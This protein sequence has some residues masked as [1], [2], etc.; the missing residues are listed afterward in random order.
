MVKKGELISEALSGVGDDLIEDAQRL[1]DED[2][3]EVQ[4]ER[5]SHDR[6]RKPVVRKAMYVFFAAAACFLLVLGITHM[7]DRAGLN[8]TPTVFYGGVRIDSEGVAAFSS[9]T[10]QAMVTDAPGIASYSLER[11][12]NTTVEE[13]TLHIE[14]GRNF[15][16]EVSSGGFLPDGITVM[17]AE[18][19]ADIVWAVALEEGAS[20][21]VK[22]GEKKVRIELHHDEVTGQW[23]LVMGKSVKNTS[24]S[25]NDDD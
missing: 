19:E 20:L 2:A 25:S 23:L 7:V 8:G 17:S 18:D 10:L 16:V 15:D 21:T 6:V 5:K 13:F 11:G 1:F 12:L 22:T 4:R 3:E 14:A 9:D 24:K